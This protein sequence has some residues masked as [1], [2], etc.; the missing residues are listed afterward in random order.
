MR[1]A[2][3]VTG[4]LTYY[5]PSL[6]GDFEQIDHRLDFAA[7]EGL[8]VAMLAPAI[9]GAS[10]F[11]ALKRKHPNFSFF[12]IRVSPAARGF[13]RRS[14]PG[15]I[16]YLART[17]LFSRHS[18]GVLAKIRRPAAP[19]P[20]LAGSRLAIS[21]RLAAVPAG[22]LTLRRV[23]E[24]LE[25]YG[26]RHAANRRRSPL[27]EHDKLADETRAFVRAVETYSCG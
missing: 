5:V 18:G 7:S 21:R 8:S 14:T 13:R 25:F 27:A 20:T 17:R 24:T 4:R 26:R 10:N 22:G 12:A 15:S 19:S 9:I 3:R 1:D 16:G 2:E 6:W 23:A 11:V